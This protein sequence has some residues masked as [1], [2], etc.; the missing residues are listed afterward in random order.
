MQTIVQDLTSILNDFERKLKAIPPA[1]FAA[2]PQPHKWSRKEVIGHL[3][4]SAQ[5]NLRRFIVGQY[6]TKA[7]ITYE[8]DFWVAANGYQAM[9]QNEII[10]LWKLLNERICAVLTNMKS[11]N[12]SNELNN[13]KESVETHSLEWLAADYVK[14]LKH[15]L[16][17]VISN[18][19]N[20]VYP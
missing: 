19:F 12:F 10:M 4:D 13:G 15:H 17:Q 5:N 1:D 11:E 20:V 6:D 18:S 14:H 8:Q 3:I 16:N 2:K 9:D 7:N